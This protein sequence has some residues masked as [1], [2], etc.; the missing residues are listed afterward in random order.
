[1]SVPQSALIFHSVATPGSASLHLRCAG[2]MSVAS[3][4][5]CDDCC[6]ALHLCDLH[7]DNL[8][9][10]DAW[11]WG[12]YLFYFILFFLNVC[13]TNRKNISQQNAISVKGETFHLSENTTQIASIL[14]VNMNLARK[15]KTELKLQAQGILEDEWWAPLFTEEVNHAA[16]ITGAPHTQVSKP[17]HVYEWQEQQT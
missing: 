17:K 15:M 12:R 1:M 6:I 8:L 5:E 14:Q 10:P 9:H 13:S 3:V 16:A 4:E 11:D 7:P 2:P